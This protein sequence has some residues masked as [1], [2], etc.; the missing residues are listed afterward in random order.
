MSFLNTKTEDK[1]LWLVL[2][3]VA[4]FF[5]WVTYTQIDSPRRWVAFCTFIFLAGMFW[6]LLWRKIK[7]QYG[8]IFWSVLA[9]GSLVAGYVTT[10]M[11]LWSFF[12]HC[13]FMSTAL[14]F[15]KGIVQPI[16]KDIR[17]D[18]LRAKLS[19]IMVVVF[20]LVL[21]LS[22]YICSVFDITSGDVTEIIIPTALIIGSI[23]LAAWLISTRRFVEVS[24]LTV[25]FIV[26]VGTWAFGSSITFFKVS[27]LYVGI[28]LL[29]LLCM[30]PVGALYYG[31]CRWQ[32][33]K[34][35]A[36]YKEIIS[37]HEK[38]DDDDPAG[39]MPYVNRK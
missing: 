34:A 25:V 9:V 37:A 39:I 15:D 5:A 10:D 32:D 11:Y 38:V 7:K 30:L 35:A 18:G 8:L 29:G 1:D 20:A 23:S 16:Q 4:S 12:Y 31:W 6:S 2:W 24:I 26:T 3:V 36:R 14:V 33:K 27:G 17:E 19:T 13:S 22:I 21:I 28:G